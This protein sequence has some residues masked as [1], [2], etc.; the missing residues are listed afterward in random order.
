MGSV[1]K[2]NCFRRIS[3]TVYTKEIELRETQLGL[4][5]EEIADLEVNQ[6]CADAELTFQRYLY[7]PTGGWDSVNELTIRSSAPFEIV[8]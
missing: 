1:E 7:K 6:I 4:L 2:V 5:C 3:S 8:M